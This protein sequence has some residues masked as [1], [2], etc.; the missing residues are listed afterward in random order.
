MVCFSLV[1]VVVLVV[2]YLLVFVLVSFILV[3]ML[4]II[5]FRLLKCWFS[6]LVGF[7]KFRCRWFGVWM[8]MVCLLEVF[9]FMSWNKVRC[10]LL[11]VGVGC[12]GLE[13]EC[14]V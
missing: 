7:R 9:M 11:F 8:W 2:C 13:I 6:V 4:L 14:L 1:L 12:F 3:L 5:R 10:V